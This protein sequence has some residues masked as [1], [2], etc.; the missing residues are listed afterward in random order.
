VRRGEEVDEVRV[1][2]ELGAVDV[3]VRGELYAFDRET[4]RYLRLTHTDHEVV[5]FVRAPGGD[6][7]A[8]V[9][10]D[11]IDR[12]KVETEPPLLA[13]AWVQALD[14]KDWKPLGPRAQL[15][16]ARALTVGYGAGDELVVQ[17]GTTSSALDRTTGKLTPVESGTLVP[18]VDVA[19]D[20]GRAHR[21]PGVALVAAADGK[22]VGIKTPSAAIQIPESGAAAEAT[23]AAAPDG[24][25]VAFATAVDPCTKDSAPSLYVA[26]ARTGTLRHVLTARSRFAT[27]WIDA[28]TLAYEDGDN[29]IRLWD[30]S[31][32]REV[33]KLDDK[34]GI[35]LDVLTIAS[36]P[37]CRV[38]PAVETGSAGEPEI[39]MPKEDVAP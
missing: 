27:R 20:D 29:A 26:D 1:A 17:V 31:S 8:V 32:A 30:A 21:Q 11:R 3:V 15:A 25:H 35:A 13:R 14:A 36:A 18:R 10:F 22:V 12:P 23:V 28:S 19:L 38:Q 39:E 37:S 6:V 33:Q 5:A 34:A 2:A 24:A 16:S 7:V 9:G 4:K